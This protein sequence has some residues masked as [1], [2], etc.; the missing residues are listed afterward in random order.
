MDGSELIRRRVFLRL[1]D[2]AV[3][4]SSSLFRGKWKTDID[5]KIIQN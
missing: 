4:L 2:I 3:A 5:S 1:E